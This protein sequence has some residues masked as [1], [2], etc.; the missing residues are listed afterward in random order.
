M[1]QARQQEGDDEDAVGSLFAGLSFP[2]VPTTIIRVPLPSPEQK[3]LIAEQTTATESHTSHTPT[4]NTIVQAIMQSTSLAS[5]YAPTA[6]AIRRSYPEISN[7]VSSTVRMDPDE[8]VGL[9][10]SSITTAQGR[11]GVSD[12]ANATLINELMQENARLAEENARLVRMQQ[13]SP[14]A[15]PIH[16]HQSI[17][18]GPVG[19]AVSAPAQGIR[20]QGTSPPA[21]R[22]G[23]KYVCCGTCRQWLLS[24]RDAVYV[25]CPQCRSVNNCGAVSHSPPAPLAQPSDPLSSFPRNFI[26]CFQGFFR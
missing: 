15:L 6:P 3:E 8:R 17:S 1:Q 10:S 13:Q 20:I 12:G 11:E 4:N 18:Q 16:N 2:E 14:Q 22:E 9:L 24:P 23:V 21:Q 7:T 5:L 25:F 26:D 19:V